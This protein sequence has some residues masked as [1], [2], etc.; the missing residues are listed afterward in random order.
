MADRSRV[1]ARRRRPARGA[2]YLATGMSAAATFNLMT[3]FSIRDRAAAQNGPEPSPANGEPTT[4]APSSTPAPQPTY[5]S[6]PRPVHTP[7][8][9]PPPPP[10]PHPRPPTPASASL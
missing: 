7:P 10:P 4:N 3:W 8:A 1:E 9:L 6:L 5:V 2:R